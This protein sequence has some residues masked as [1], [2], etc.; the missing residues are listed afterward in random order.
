MTHY[1]IVWIEYVREMLNKWIEDKNAA[2]YERLI[3]KDD[4]GHRVAVDNM[5][6]DFWM[7]DFETFEEAA[8]RCEE[9]N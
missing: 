5:T 7:E 3:A 4:N 1:R 2:P 6:H 9:Y 8:E